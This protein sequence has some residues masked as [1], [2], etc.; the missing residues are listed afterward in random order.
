M[1]KLSEDEE[2]LVSMTVSAFSENGGVINRFV[3][4]DLNM[5]VIRRLCEIHGAELHI[6]ISIGKPITRA[7]YAMLFGREEIDNE[8]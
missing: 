2:A 5:E 3:Q 6:A 7:G 4:T 8:V 1:R